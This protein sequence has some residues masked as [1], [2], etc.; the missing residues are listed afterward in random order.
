MKGEA[1]ASKPVLDVSRAQLY[2][3]RGGG[4]RSPMG[5]LCYLAMDEKV[6][7]RSIPIGI[8]LPIECRLFIINK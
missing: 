7:I 4:K 2:V 1:A 8:L 3:T 5:V 6:G